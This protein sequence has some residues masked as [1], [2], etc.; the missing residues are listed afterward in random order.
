MS[1]NRLLGR[2]RDWRILSHRPSTGESGRRRSWRQAGYFQA[3]GEIVHGRVFSACNSLNS[4]EK[5]HFF[6]VDDSWK[7]V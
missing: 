2:L 4:C 1:I 7:K 6:T 3:L 5:I